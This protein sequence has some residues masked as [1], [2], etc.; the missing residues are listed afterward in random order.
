MSPVNS[1]NTQIASPRFNVNRSGTIMQG[2]IDGDRMDLRIQWS[3]TAAKTDFDG[4]FSLQAQSPQR[5]AGSGTVTGFKAGPNSLSCS[6]V[7]VGSR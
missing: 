1:D 3:S 4:K 7:L 2:S 5:F 6:I